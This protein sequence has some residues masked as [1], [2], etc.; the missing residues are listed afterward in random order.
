MAW[1]LP[2]GGV[3]VTPESEGVVKQDDAGESV[4]ELMGN[5]PHLKREIP[6]VPIAEG[7]PV[8]LGFCL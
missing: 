7:S 4:D 8:V 6:V 3:I 1:E 2:P 5:Y